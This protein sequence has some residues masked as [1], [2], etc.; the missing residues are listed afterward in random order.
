LRNNKSLAF[1][2]TERE[3]WQLYRTQEILVADF[4]Y[5]VKTHLQEFG[6]SPEENLRLLKRF[7]EYTVASVNDA[8][9]RAIRESKGQ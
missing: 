3:R 2:K 9:H 5:W 8:A 6:K 7:S 1:E 4:D